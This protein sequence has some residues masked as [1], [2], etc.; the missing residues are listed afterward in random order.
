MATH[1]ALYAADPSQD[2][3]RNCLTDMLW[4]PAVHNCVRFTPTW[5]THYL[6]LSAN[7]HTS[8]TMIL[9]YC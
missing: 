3:H 1:S 4:Q 8:L 7:F 2:T 9:T 5:S 6:Q